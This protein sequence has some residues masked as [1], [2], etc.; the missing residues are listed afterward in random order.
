MEMKRR[1]EHQE[2]TQMTET[3][4]H[5]RWSVKLGLWESEDTSGKLL[6]WVTE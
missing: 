3:Y 4:V 5:R 2:I 1:W 6:V